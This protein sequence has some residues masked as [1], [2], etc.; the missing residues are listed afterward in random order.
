MFK[1]SFKIQLKPLTKEILTDEWRNKNSIKNTKSLGI[2]D[3]ESIILEFL[4][5]REYGLAYEHLNYVISETDMQV[6]KLHIE[7]LQELEFILVQKIKDR[8]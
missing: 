7:K 4:E 2:K 6:S 1:S 3:A 5:H 8:I